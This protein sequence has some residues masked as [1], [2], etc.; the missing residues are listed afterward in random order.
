MSDD[1]HHILVIDDD[2]PL[3]EL[4]LRFLS[5]KG[6]RVTGSQSAAEARSRLK[7]T[8]FDA[9]VVDIMMPNETG[10]ELVRS[11]KNTNSD[12][13]CL[14]LTA[15]GEPGE[16]LLGLE[17]GADDYMTKPFEPEELALRIRNLLRRTGGAETI[18]THE[19]GWEATVNFGPHKFDLATGQLRTG[20]QRNHLTTA[21]SVLLK[22]FASHANQI[23]ARPDL[24]A[25]IENP[26]EDRSLDVAVARL[27]RKIEPNPRKPIY[28]LTLRN[29]GWVLQADNAKQEG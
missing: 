19:T 25:M 5:G 22:C 2:K 7:G 24:V 26:M 21:E 9:L 29:Q 1:R 4:L 12:L 13:P 23:L 16:R 11:L 27:R 28:L 14:M 8:Y 3:L 15:M 18:D 10:L 6:Y 20:N 17:S